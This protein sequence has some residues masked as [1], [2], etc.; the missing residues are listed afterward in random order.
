MRILTII[1]ALPFV[2]FAAEGDAQKKK[3]WT[4]EAE[5]S[6][7]Q[8]DGN[9]QSGSLRATNKYAYIKDRSKLIW[10][11]RALRVETTKTTVTATGT[12]EEPVFEESDDTSVA[13]EK[14]RTLLKY[15]RT[16]SERTSWF[17]SGSWEKDEP[18]GI[19]NRSRVVL[20]VSNKWVKSKKLAFSTN[21]GAGYDREDLV[22]S[23]QK[24][25][26]AFDMG[27]EWMVKL[28]NGRFDQKLDG[29]LSEKDTEDWRLRLEN[30]LTFDLNKTLA[31]RLGIDV[32]Y[33]NQPN[34]IKVDLIG[35]GQKVD[36]PLD[37]LDSQITAALVI[38]F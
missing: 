30:D 5:L 24:D 22:N 28:T 21:Y 3:H 9:S 32:E 31:T 6:A 1:F 33:N 10:Q 38:N 11:V 23:G 15:E 18:K 35:T 25:F 34:I 12:A 37:E 2:V 16:I 13:S 20:G 7:V 27:Y 29:D 19:N 8:T 26:L 4:N 36:Y 14:L 17:V